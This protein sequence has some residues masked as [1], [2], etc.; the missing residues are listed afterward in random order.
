M[1]SSSPFIAKAVRAITG[2]ERVAR[3]PL[4]NTVAARPSM[5]GSWISIRINWG[6]SARASFSPVSA[7]V[8]LRTVWPTDSSRKSANVMFAALSSTIRTVA[9]S[10]D[11]VAPR[12]G[13]PDFHP[14][15]VT[16]ELSLFHDR[17]HMA[18]Q[19]RAL[20]GGGLFG[21]D[22]EDRDAGRLGTFVKRLHDVEA[23]HVRH[24]QIEH[25]Q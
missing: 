14:E 8:A 22:H 23:V 6:C 3:P 24:H 9:M 16:V 11:R 4:S 15:P 17:R 7:F 5:P 10:G 12:H 13:P 18:A 25:D 1:R 2:M 21:G 19:L 20:L